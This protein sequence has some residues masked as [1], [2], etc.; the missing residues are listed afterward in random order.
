MGSAATKLSSKI[1]AEVGA[2]DFCARMA[3]APA[4]AGLN[5]HPQ[6]LLEVLGG[7]ANLYDEKSM[8]M[9]LDEFQVNTES[10]FASS[11]VPLQTILMEIGY[12][13]GY[14]ERACAQIL[15]AMESTLRSYFEDKDAHGELA[16][17]FLGTVRPINLEQSTYNLHYRSSR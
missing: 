4:L 10:G 6:Q 11:Y 9:E 16:L 13:S 8:E 3:S 1:S 5:V 14:K 17:K 12:A 15:S 2:R 7:I